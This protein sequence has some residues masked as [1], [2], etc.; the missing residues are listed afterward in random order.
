MLVQKIPMKSKLRKTCDVWCLSCLI[1]YLAHPF[2]IP[3]WKAPF[4]SSAL[5][6]RRVCLRKSQS[7][8]IPCCP[9]FSSVQ[10]CETLALRGLLEAALSPEQSPGNKTTR[11]GHSATTICDA[12]FFTIIQI[13]TLV[14]GKCGILLMTLSYSCKKWSR[15]FHVKTSIELLTSG[16]SFGVENLF[17]YLASCLKQDLALRYFL[18]LWIVFLGCPTWV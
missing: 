16:K 12:V 10:H 7:S 15:S 8:F 11:R 17:S 14:D 5:E 9:A 4:E 1:V 13:R 2:Q 18:P 6:H 3:R